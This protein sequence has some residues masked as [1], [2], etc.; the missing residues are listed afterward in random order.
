V[1]ALVLVPIA[2]STKSQLLVAGV[3]A[4]ID[5]NYFYFHFYSHNL[6][7]PLDA[8]NPIA[9]FDNIPTFLD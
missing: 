4:S 1:A 7:L 9:R 3:F 6:L 2:V 5:R 8:A